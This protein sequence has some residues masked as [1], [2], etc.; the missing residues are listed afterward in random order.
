[1]SLLARDN[2]SATLYSDD[3]D[4][5]D[6]LDSHT[7][8]DADAAVSESSSHLE[9]ISPVNKPKPRSVQQISH[10]PVTVPVISRIPQMRGRPVTNRLQPPSLSLLFLLFRIDHLMTLSLRARVA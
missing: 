7:V 8:S 4:D 1:M 5:P 2:T 3:S 9:S 10:P 6:Y